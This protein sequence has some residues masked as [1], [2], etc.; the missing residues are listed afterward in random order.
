MIDL[1]RDSKTNPQNQKSLD[2]DQDSQRNQTA[3]IDR[4]SIVKREKIKIKY[5]INLIYDSKLQS[6]DR[7]QKIRRNTH[8]I[9]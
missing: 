2:L 1:E 5:K 3:K 8:N 4:K 9:T 7:K 6:N